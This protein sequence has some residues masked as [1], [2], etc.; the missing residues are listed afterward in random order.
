MVLKL[1]TVHVFN[2]ALSIFQRKLLLYVFSSSSFYVECT[3]LKNDAFQCKKS[4]VFL[5]ENKPNFPAK[6]E[7]ALDQSV[8]KEN[9]IFVA[10]VEKLR[11][12]LLE[13]VGANSQSTR[14]LLYPF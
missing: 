9:W 6:T 4:N 7:S 12:R 3:S 5:F 11:P 1:L 13:L 10:K 14:C 8:K 2:N